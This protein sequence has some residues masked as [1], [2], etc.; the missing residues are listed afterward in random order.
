MSKFKVYLT[1]AGS[2][3]GTHEE[4]SEM[5]AVTWLYPLRMAM[6][7]VQGHPGAI[8]MAMQPLLMGLGPV[9]R[10]ENV[11]LSGTILCEFQDAG[12][13]QKYDDAV[14]QIRAQKSGLKL[15]SPSDFPS[16]QK[17]AAA[18]LKIVKP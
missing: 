4:V 7:P 12:L 14:M 18:H 15:A 13:E 6:H 11:N 5:G 10:V 9:D 1:T 2:M 3:I 17:R 16:E 8:G